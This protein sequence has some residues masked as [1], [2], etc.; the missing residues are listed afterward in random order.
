MINLRESTLIVA[1]ALSLSGCGAGNVVGSALG[2]SEILED[3]GAGQPLGVLQDGGFVQPVG[4]TSGVP[5]QLTELFGRGFFSFN[6]TNDQTV[7]VLE[8]AFTTNSVSISESGSFSL[9]TVARLTSS[10]DEGVTIEDNGTRDMYCTYIDSVSQYLCLA[11]LAEGATANFLLDRLVDNT[12]SG[13]FE[14]C[15]ASETTEVCID[16]LVNEPDGNARL[17]MVPGGTAVAE[18]FEPATYPP[19]VTSAENRLRY[20]EQ[21]TLGFNANN[22]IVTQRSASQDLLQAARDQLLNR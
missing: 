20:L 18:A 17:R 15:E 16:G 7:Y 13:T 1:V 8:T 10:D 14:F 11:A 12:S 19:V 4:T 21:G 6:I 5:Q 22:G 3:S 2:L 9:L